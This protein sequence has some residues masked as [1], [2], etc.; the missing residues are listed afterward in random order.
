MWMMSV[1][2]GIDVSKATLDLVLLTDSGTQHQQFPNTVAGFEQLHQWLKTQPPMTRV[3]MEAS[4]RYG[5]G[6]LYF[7]LEQGYPVSYLNPKQ[8]HAFAEVHLHYNKT[9][10]QDALLIARDCQLHQPP[11]WQPT[12]P[13]QRQ[14]QQRSRRLHALQKMRQQEEQEAN[15]LHAGLT[16]PFVVKQIRL[17][18]AHFDRLIAQTQ[19][20]MH[21]L[22][23]QS[24]ALRAHALKISASSQHV[25]SCADRQEIQNWCTLIL[26]FR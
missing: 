2:V 17:L 12:S 23:A 25:P 10:K 16:D 20:A 19:Q 8:I 5:E 4:G 14:L 26:I 1:F 18:I 9:D 22:V 13:L 21:A 24:Q 6:L 7:L 11:V 15:R 3:G